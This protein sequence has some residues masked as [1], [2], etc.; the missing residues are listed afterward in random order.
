MNK[1]ILPEPVSI[2]FTNLIRDIENGM[3]KIPNF[4]REFVWPIKKTIN[5]LDSISKGYPIGS[6][7]I[8]ET[9]ERLLDLRNIGDM[10]LPE[11]PEGNVVKYVLDGQQRIT[12]LFACMK[13]V[14][15]DQKPYHLFYDLEKKIFTDNSDDNGPEKLVPASFLLRED[16]E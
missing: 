10:P 14:H 15:I 6:F 7:L 2:S 12:S 3:I 4:Q 16:D 1:I 13:E 11:T 8:W 5:L 9:N